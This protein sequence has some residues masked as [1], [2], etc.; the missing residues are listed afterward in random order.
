M[1][2]TLLIRD[3]NKAYIDT[4]LWIPKTAGC[5]NIM[6]YALTL[7]PPGD[8]EPIYLW[9]ETES[10]IGIPRARVDPRT[11]DVEVVDLRPKE[12]EKTGIRD[13]IVLDA[14]NPK[15]NDQ[16]RAYEDLMVAGSGILNMKCGGGKTVIIL[17]CISTWGFPTLIINDKIQILH[18]WIKEI[19]QHLTDVGDIGWIQGKPDTWAWKNKITM[20]SLSTLAK[21]ADRIPIEMR[22]YFGVVVWDE[23]H[24]L[25]ARQFSKTADKFYGRRIGATATFHRDDGYEVIYDAHIGGIIHK[26]LKHDLIPRVVFIRS[27]VMIDS[28]K[29]SRQCRS[30]NGQIN[31]IRLSKLVGAQDDERKFVKEIIDGGIERKKNMIGVSL[32]AEYMRDLHDDYPKSGLL[33]G[34]V[35]VDDRLE[36]FRKKKLVFGT[37]KMLQEALDKAKLDTIIILTEFSS[38]NILQQVVGRCQRPMKGKQARVIIVW[39]HQIPAMYK[40]GKNLMSHFRR[41]GFRIEVR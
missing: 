17:K 6:K 25:G 37:A 4:R 20:A 22:R 19:E 34:D 32:S 23:I 10:H 36:I 27:P 40:M 31:V 35:P 26:N 12:Y 39:H 1:K 11:L 3:P 28:K 7:S 38:E 16:K 5:A 30:R 29:I 15:S 24:H 41:W 9:E 21:Y 13:H 2:Y 14:R 18:Q 8:E 33:L